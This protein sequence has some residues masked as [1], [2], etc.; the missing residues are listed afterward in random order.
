VRALLLPLVLTLIGCDSSSDGYLYPP[1]TG[2][3]NV[4]DMD[5]DTDAQIANT[6]G[7]DRPAVLVEYQAGGTWNVSTTCDTTVSGYSCAWDL[8]LSLDA[9]HDLTI[10]DDKTDLE[11][12][13]RV[14]TIDQGAVRAIFETES[15]V[16]Q[17]TLASPPGDK[18]QIDAVLD[19]DL[20]DPSFISWTSGG[21]VA[22]AGSNPVRLTPTAP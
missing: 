22:N 21:N 17:I 1:V 3:S 2:P 14:L 18:L 11:S 16:D 6:P 15:D 9:G 20:A 19:G 4:L 8:V 13:D 7:K 10:L 12:A 5:I